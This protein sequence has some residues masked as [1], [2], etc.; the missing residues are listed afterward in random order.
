MKLL[1]RNPKSFGIRNPAVNACVVS[2]R[3]II[4]QMKNVRD[5]IFAEARDTL[6]H[7]ERMLKLALNEAEALAW[8]TAVPQLV[9]PTLAAEKVR[10]LEDWNT[11]QQF[12]GRKDH[13]PARGPALL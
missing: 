4:A 2:C 8:Q 1:N 6:R 5:A 13:S 3:K 10:A 11:R 7:Q 9:F 12:M